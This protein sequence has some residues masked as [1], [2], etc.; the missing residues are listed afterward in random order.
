MQNGRQ[1]WGAAT[2]SAE[3]NQSEIYFTGHS[4]VPQTASVS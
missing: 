2:V 4:P 3:T 1:N